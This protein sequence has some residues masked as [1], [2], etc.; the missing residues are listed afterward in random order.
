MGH[1]GKT[2]ISVD[3]LYHGIINHDRLMLSKAITLIESR[4]KDDITRGAELLDKIISHSGK[5]IRL[6]ITGVPGVGKSSFIES[7]GSQLTQKGHRLAI[8]S[9]DPSSSKSGGSILGDKTRMEQLS[10]DP[11][12]YIRPSPAGQTLGGV[13]NKTR[14]TILLCEAAGFDIIIVETVGVGQSETAVKDMVDCFLLLMLSGGGDELQGIK[15][16]IMEMAD[17]IAINK[18]DG[19]NVGASKQTKKI[20]ENAVHLFPPHEI[21]WVVPVSLCSALTKHGITEI[22][23]DINRFIALSQS[24]NF[25]KHNRQI[26]NAHWYRQL[27]DEEIK[28]TYFDEEKRARYR[29]IEAKIIANEMG[30]RNGLRKLFES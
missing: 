11:N 29:Q 2:R 17:I 22:W 6:G 3:E 7:F 30:V 26:Q 10:H 28:H 12:A 1:F 18:S 16:G 9:I 8:L 13:N 15:R 4:R 20:L 21:N 19:D 5:S 24:E 27:V 25:F 14:E 23:D